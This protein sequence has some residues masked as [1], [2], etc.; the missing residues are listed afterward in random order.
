MPREVSN[1]SCFADILFAPF[2]AGGRI[3]H[4]DRLLGENSFGTPCADIVVDVVLRR[5]VP[6]PEQLVHP[7]I[8][9]EHPGGSQDLSPLRSE[10]GITLASA[11]GAV[12]LG[13][14]PQKALLWRHIDTI[15]H[16][17]PHFTSDQLLHHNPS[18]SPNRSFHHDTATE[19]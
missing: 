19:R 10:N 11:Q 16:D 8:D 18:A 4:D 7:L 1:P 2:H 13:T 6:R 17:F 14:L 5:W 12:G 15:S 9:P 3:G